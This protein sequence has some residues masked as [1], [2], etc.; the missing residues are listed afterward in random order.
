MSETPPPLTKPDP[1]NAQA[2]SLVDDLRALIDD[3]RTFVEA[4]LAYQSSRA[5][6]AGKGIK[7]IALFGVLGAA[8]AFFALMALIVGAVI[9]LVPVLSAWGATA[10]VCGACLLLTAVCFAIASSRWKHMAKQIAGKDVGE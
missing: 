1:S 10:A 2:R 6:F 5:R 3:G 9:A 4:E 8:L 7:S